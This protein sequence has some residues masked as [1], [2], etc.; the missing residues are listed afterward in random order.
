M[1]VEFTVGNF[2][3]F[4][5]K[6]TLS[7]EAASIKENLDNIIKVGKHQILR[8]AVI[9]GANSSGKSNFLG[10]LETMSKFVKSSGKSNSTDEIE[11]TPFLLSTETEGM[12]SHFEVV[13]IMGQ[14]LF[15]YG[16]EADKK[17][18]QVEWL[19]RTEDGG[20]EM[21]LFIREG[22][23]IEISESFTE[24]RDLQDKTRSNALFL[25]VVDQFNGAI[26]KKVI[27]W[28][29]SQVNFSGLRHEEVKYVSSFLLENKKFNNFI[30][31]FLIPLDLGFKDFSFD[32]KEKRVVTYHNKYDESGTVVD[33][34]FKF[35]LV[36]QESAGTNK[37]YD[38]AGRLSL[39]LLTGG[40]TIIDELDAKLHPLLTMAIVKLFN[41]PL[42]NRNNAQLVFAT[43]DTNLL[44]HS[45][46]R[47]D[48]IYFT[49][50]TKFEST[51]LYSLVEY[52][53][54]DG[55]KIRNDR[56]FEKDYIAGRYRAIPYMGDFS[57]LTGK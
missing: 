4:K 31:D 15:R 36:T 12:P 37:L 49:E 30:K 5:E 17:A 47:R 27:E 6:K 40:V 18:V 7:L 21:E 50:K 1:L 20:K 51:D 10:A 44:S 55:S 38:M 25:S 57:L 23:V 14:D 39:G 52:R 42:H 13:F 33:D 56:S 29:S 45:C 53:E 16:F 35:D 2:L 41:S 11:V 32:E 26:S 8:S 28:F 19:F 48:Q 46:F 3:S 43:H 54:P 24:A 9:Y 22:E 34:K